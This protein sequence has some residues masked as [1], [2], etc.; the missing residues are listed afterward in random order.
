[1]A[2]TSTSHRRC[3]RRANV[4]VPWEGTVNWR[5]CP[6]VAPAHNRHY[7]RFLNAVISRTQVPLSR[8]GWA[9]PSPNP[10]SSSSVLMEGL[11]TLGGNHGSDANG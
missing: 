5:I 6:G 3:L 4:F 10:S 8:R 9:V 1:M 2:T 11:T 7:V